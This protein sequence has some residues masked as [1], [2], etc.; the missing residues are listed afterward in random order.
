MYYTDGA[1]CLLVLLAVHVRPTKICV[2]IIIVIV[3]LKFQYS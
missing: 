2:V 1:L 3:T